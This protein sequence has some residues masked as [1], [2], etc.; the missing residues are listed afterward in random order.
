MSTKSSKTPALTST[1]VADATLGVDSRLV[2]HRGYFGGP[3]SSGSFTIDIGYPFSGHLVQLIPIPTAGKS[4][5][6]KQVSSE[7]VPGNNQVAVTY[8]IQNA[9]DLAQIAYTLFVTA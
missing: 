9:G 1:N 4:C 6:V 5:V 3:F 7:P 2:I 8:N